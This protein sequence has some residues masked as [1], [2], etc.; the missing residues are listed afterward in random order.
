MLQRSL[1]TASRHGSPSDQTFFLSFTAVDIFQEF[2]IIPG[3]KRSRIIPV[4]SV[5][6]GF[7]CYF[8]KVLFFYSKFAESR[9]FNIPCK[10][11]DF[12]HCDRA[13]LFFGGEAETHCFCYPGIFLQAVIHIV[14]HHG[15]K[16]YGIADTMWQVVFSSKSF[17]YA[18]YRR[19]IRVTETHTG[20]YASKK[21]AGSCFNVVSIIISSPEVF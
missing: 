12:L 17:G 13:S 10:L 11:C 8:L 18:V 15:G 4:A 7:G 5:K 3:L 1:E 20:Q 16:D 21:H 19:Y 9:K 2:K 6:C 14:L